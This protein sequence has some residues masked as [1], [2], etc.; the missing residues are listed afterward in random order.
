[1]YA[2]NPVFVP[3]LREEFRV[4]PTSLRV[5]QGETAL[6][7]CGPPRGQPEPT[8]FWKK[9]GQVLEIDN[10]KRIQVVD[11]GNLAIQD[12]REEDEGQY[13]CVAKNTVGLRESTVAN[14]KVDVR[15]FLIQGPQDVTVQVG[16]TVTFTCVVGGDPLPDVMWRRG[17]GNMPL[18]RVTVLQDRSLKIQSVTV[19]DQGEYV[20]D[21]DNA[22]GSLVASAVLTVHS[23]P[24]ILIQPADQE[25]EEGREAMFV[26]GVEGKPE[27]VLFWSLEGNHS[28]VFPGETQGRLRAALNSAGHTVLI[29]Q[30]VQRNDSGLTVMCAAVNSAGSDVL[31]ARLT[32]TSPEHLPPPV[33]ELGPANQTLP[34]RTLA[35][36]RCLAT[37]S[38]P[39]IITWYKGG[40]PVTKG[41]DRINI[42]ETG[43]LVINDTV[44]SDEG[45]YT[46]VASSRSGKATW[47]AILKLESRTNPNAHFFRSPELTTLPGPPSRPV[48]VNTTHNSIT[49]SWTRNNKIGSSSLLG[50]QVELFS[51]DPNASGR[52]GGGSGW[53]VVARRVPG[54]TYTQ[55]HLG[56]GLLYTF[57]VR[58]ENSHGLSPP[59]PPST[60]TVLSLGVRGVEGGDH[61]LKEAQASLSAGH[62]V[63]LT[64]I[65]PTSATSIKLAWE[66]VNADFVEGF[67]IYSRSLDSHLKSTNMLTVLHA[68]EASGFLVTGLRPFT[69]YLFFLIPFYKNVDGRPS[70]SR[71]A[72]TM[73]DVPTEAPQDMEAVLLNSTAVFLKWKPPPP[74]SCNGVLRSY[75]VVVRAGHL[76]LSN[77]SVPADTPSL[78][79]TNLTA[80]VVYVVEAA[81]ATR[82]GAGPYTAPATL[83]LDPSMPYNR[84]P[85]GL[86]SPVASSSEFVTETWFVAL[87]GSLLTVMLLMFAAMLIVRRRQLLA[88]KTN[89]PDCHSNAGVLAT[90]VNL[91]SGTQTEASLWIE[92]KTLGQSRTTPDY[93]EVQHRTV[94]TFQSVDDGSGAAYATTTLVPPPTS[95][96]SRDRGFCLESSREPLYSPP[97]YHS[98]LYS[99]TYCLHHNLGNK[100]NGDIDS[101]SLRRP[102]H[103]SPSSLRAQVPVPS[104]P[105]SEPTLPPSLNHRP[106]QW[107]LHSPG[108]N[109]TNYTL[110]S[111]AHNQQHIYQHNSCRSEPRGS[112]ARL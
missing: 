55:T 102:T 95:H 80:G 6:L 89:L 17:G 33:I 81:G 41:H 103:H 61:Q 18:G 37:G 14:L 96:S 53:V 29:I 63:E 26:C 8:V 12:V 94:T 49:V 51:R 56:P 71:S 34:L 112:A 58:A 35:V 54:P 77:I 86:E 67:Y 60:P 93:A 85:V 72:R 97:S 10:P 73:E 4:E 99:D 108:G 43:T 45:V 64:A 27:P 88:K 39:P 75:Q 5:A 24:V 90:P 101:S 50:Y 57:L 11:G 110:S 98:R 44:A 28:L 3:V 9:N 83:R 2:P 52:S 106:L 84:R 91:K 40:V 25:V 70:N 23:P 65:Q 74:H 109:Y 19:E 13:Q 111:F 42:T 31:R 1:M 20:C 22:V 21:V 69:R 104:E 62:V 78:L 7:E 105:C 16:G 32:V 30:D 100:S 107:R 46:C 79:L 82:V 48:I 66:I 36:L 15:P 76:V 59:S 92:P 68:G 87:L 47:S 38:P